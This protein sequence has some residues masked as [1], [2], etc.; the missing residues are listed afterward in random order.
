MG[1]TATTCESNQMNTR[2]CG[3]N[4]QLLAAVPSQV[5]V[6]QMLVAIQ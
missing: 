2:I 1:T 3:A 6:N 5:A 4:V